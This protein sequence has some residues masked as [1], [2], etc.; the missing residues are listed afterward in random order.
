MEVEAEEKASPWL[1]VQENVEMEGKVSLR[2]G[3]TS[4]ATLALSTA[5]VDT[6]NFAVFL[7]KYT[8]WLF[9]CSAPKND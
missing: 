5:M 4:R 9:Y 2:P 8:G 6:G 1:E 7:L 3:P